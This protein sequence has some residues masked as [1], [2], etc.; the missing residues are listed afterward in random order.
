MR[1]KKSSQQQLNQIYAMQDNIS[2]FL[3]DSTIIDKSVVQDQVVPNNDNSAKSVNDAL[4]ELDDNDS[5]KQHDEASITFNS[6][7]GF[8]SV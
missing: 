7:F 4:N 8:S 2:N 6:S 5:Q 1:F 3:H